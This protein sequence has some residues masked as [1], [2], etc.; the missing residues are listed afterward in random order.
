MRGV[1]APPLLDLTFGKIF[2]IIN[3]QK[4]WKKGESE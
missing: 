2:G 4:I 3:L 1:S